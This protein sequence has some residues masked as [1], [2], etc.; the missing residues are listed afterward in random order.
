ME[1]PPLNPILSHYRILSKIGAGGMG[2]MYLAEDTRLDRMRE[3]GRKVI[4]IEPDFFGG[5][6][7]KHFLYRSTRSF[8]PR[9]NQAYQ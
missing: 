7:G 4:E 6:G 8:W 5:S 1:E 9:L 2:E 3:Q